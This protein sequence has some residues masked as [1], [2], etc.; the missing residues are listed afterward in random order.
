[1]PRMERTW[2]AD[3][4]AR[5]PGEFHGLRAVRGLRHNGEVRF[6]IED[7]PH[8]CGHVLK[9]AADEDLVSAC[10]AAMRGESFLY[11]G[12][13]GRLVRDFLDRMR[14]GERMPQAVLTAREGELL[15]LSRP[16]WA[17]A[18]ARGRGGRDPME[19]RLSPGCGR[20]PGE[21]GGIPERL[22]RRGRTRISRAFRDRLTFSGVT[23][24]W[25]CWTPA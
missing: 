20:R 11:T 12:V 19:I 5:P 10:P 24:D 22:G 3:A 18:P 15:K 16:D 4:W 6:G 1:M 2:S 13:A 8:P 17:L 23:S 14:R 9:S 7:P 21:H 25:R